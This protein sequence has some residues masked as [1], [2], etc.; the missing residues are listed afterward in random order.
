MP[1]EVTNKTYPGIICFTVILF[2][3]MCPYSYAV[4]GTHVKFA[5][6]VDKA[7]DLDK[8]P[9]VSLLEVKLS[10]KDGIKLLER[11]Q[12]RQVLEEQELSLAGLLQ[13]NRAI[14]IG[15]LLRVDAFVLLSIEDS[16][17]EKQNQKRLLRVRVTETAHGLRLL[18]TF[19]E[20]DS[21]K[22]EKIVERIT[23]KVVAIVPKMTLLSGEAIPVGIVDI[24]RV[25]LGERYQWLARSLPVMLSNRLNK[26]P[27]II[28]LEREDL[29]ILHD[30]KLLTD[31]EDTEFWGS[32]V[33]I[34]GY[35][36]P[37]GATNIE[38]QLSLRRASGKE[39][40]A[41]TVYVE[42]NEPW[43]AVDE[44]T[45]QVIQDLLNAPPSTSWQP[46]QEAEEFYRQ[47]QLLRSHKRHEDALPPLETAH[48]LQP[49]NV[50]YTGA[51]FENEWDVRFPK[52][53]GSHVKQTGIKLYSDLEL[54]QIV[55]LLVHQMQKEYGKGSL[56]VEYVIE[57]WAEPL[58]LGG[59]QWGYF[60][61]PD[62]IST[63]KIRF[64]NRDN[65]QIFAETIKQAL[66]D[67]LNTYTWQWKGWTLDLAWSSSDNPDEL[68]KN[69]Q[70]TYAPFIMPREMG[71][72]DQ[73]FGKR[74][75]L[76]R[77]ALLFP[78]ISFMRRAEQA[79]NTHLKGRYKRFGKLW[80]QYLEDLTKVQDPLL[81]LT[82]CMALTF[83]YSG[84]SPEAKDHCE[85]AIKV[86]LEEIKCP[87]EPMHDGYKKLLRNR[88]KSCILSAGFE[89]SHT[90]N[91]FER[92]YEPLIEKG[93]AHNLAV[94]NPC[95]HFSFYYLCDTPQTAKRC[96]KLLEKIAA[97]LDNSEDTEDTRSAL[98]LIKDTLA[99]FSD[100]YPNLV[101]ADRAKNL[102]VTLLLN[103]E[104]WPKRK[105]TFKYIR[106]LL[107]GNMLWIAFAEPEVGL[108]GINLTENR[109]A[110]VQHVNCDRGTVLHANVKASK[111][112]GSITG[113]ADVENECYVSIRDVGLVRF[114]HNTAKSTEF[115]SSPRIL[116]E[117]DGL[118][119]ASITGMAAVN[120]KLW[121]AYGGRGKESGLIIYDAQNGNWETVFCSSL[122][123]ND[124][125]S[126]GQTYAISSLTPGPKNKL[127][128]L[129]GEREFDPKINYQLEQWWGLWKINTN[130]KQPEHLWHDDQ[131]PLVLEN[132]DDFGQSWWLRDL[133][134]LI[135][136]DPDS[137]TAAFIMGW[138][139]VLRKADPMPQLVQ[140]L[141]VPESSP[142][143][144]ECGFTSSGF[145]DLRTAAV[146]QDKLWARLGESQ[147][148]AI[149][150]GKGFEEAEIIDNNILN[151]NKVLR[152]FSTPYGLI[153]VGEGTV[154]LIETKSNL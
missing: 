25:Q 10:Q 22:L 58:G 78:M 111:I 120:N 116:T 19:E 108:A 18:D 6:I 56:P 106:A 73:S 61:R 75:S 147:L 48:A 125:F 127:F 114:A 14:Q 113:I 17:Q 52:G 15:Q 151:G 69:I 41:F 4:L 117:E 99:R 46:E 84:K 71:G 126:S 55:S 121:I 140:D 80:G 124:P 85:N 95:F 30:E 110:S 86:L 142:N 107:K 141:F 66:K 9:L 88:M 129:L 31:G 21:A 59:F 81:N 44:V 70:K 96:I 72:R 89:K 92:I 1:R 39:E 35:L 138:S 68:I 2:C 128:F 13:R 8:S 97:V 34:D 90:I 24:H 134:S 62:S 79:E 38:M 82:A 105:N 40:A 37:R 57:R 43:A 32:A 33:L 77:S 104:D 133:R 47:G 51:L 53:Q 29:K 98:S 91:T 87:N 135:R 136:F 60:L 122:K 109:Q 119:S 65:R 103:K 76:C 118:P 28:M 112:S 67:N 94:W 42:P 132:I 150:K 145:I 5:L 146:H 83:H 45:I 153:A 131:F 115:Q 137:E 93:D 49:N 26:E 63:E 27:R 7:F 20:L 54:A 152:F 102:A 3:L 123:G 36:Q 139:R 130:T 149:H 16:A 64:I 101:A 74:F 12:I 23:E 143:K 100:K 50:F 11:A 144:I 154:G 148:I